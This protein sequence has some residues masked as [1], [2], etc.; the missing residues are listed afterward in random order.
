MPAFGQQA[1]QYSF[2]H[3]SVSDGLAANMVSVVVQDK[4]GYMWIATLNGL[5]RYDGSSFITFKSDEKNPHTIPSNHILRLH[6]DRKNNLWVI[7]ENNEVGIFD[8]KKFVYKKIAIPIEKRKFF[9]PQNF[10]EMPTGELLLV[11]TD[12]SLLQYTEAESKFTPVP[13]LIPVPPKWK[14]NRVAW[15]PSIKKFWITT[16]SGL[17]QYNP[18][19]KTLNYRGHNTENDPVIKSFDKKVY[20]FNVFTD[21]KGNVL[22]YYWEKIDGEPYVFRYHRK[23]NKGEIFTIH[24]QSTHHDI[25]GFLQQQDGKLWVYGKPFFAEMTDSENPFLF[26]PNEYRNEQ[27]IKFDYAFQSFEDRERNIWIATDN[28]LF[29]FNP[30]AQIFNTYNLIRPGDRQ[31][32]LSSVKSIAEMS[33]GKI[34]VGSMGAGLFYFDNNFNPLP[35]P[36]SLEPAGRSLLIWDMAINKKTGDLW[37]AMESGNLGIYNHQKN[38]YTQVTPEI[39]GNTIISHID[40]D[41]SGNIW[42]GTN[43][44]KVV[45]WDIKKAGNDPHKGYEL[46]CETS[47]IRK[48]HYDYQGYVW[49]GTLG[50]GVLK[51]DVR[52]NKII[53]T[54][55]PDNK[56]GE[57]LF[58]Y[59]PEDMTYYNDSTLLI[60]TGCINIVNTKTNKISFLTTQHGLPSN[61]IQSIQ[62]DKTGIVWVGMTNGICRVNLQKKIISYYDR[63]DGIAD[64]K[65]NTAGVE[66]LKDGR[67]LFLTDHNFLL[68]NPK[69]FGQQDIPPKPFVTSFKLA[70]KPLLMDSLEKA[71]KITLRHNKTSIAIDFTAFRYLQQRKLHYFYMLEGLDKEWVHTDYPV[72]AVYNFLPPGDYTFK[73]KS[74][75]ADGM[76]SQEIA[77][78]PIIVRP[79]FWNTWWFYGLIILLIITVLYMLDHERMS[80]RRL[81]QHMRSQIGMN[82][83]KEVSTTLNNINVLSE[84]AKIKADKNIEQSKDY[85]DQISYKSRYMIEA[86]DDML[87]SI[88]PQNDSMKKTVLRIKELT[89]GFKSAYNVDIDLIVASKVEMLELNMKL[90]HELYFFYKEAIN[91]FI[92]HIC[93]NQIFVSINQVRSRL[94]IE[95]LSE[96]D[97]EASA[98]TQSFKKA[99]HKRLEVLSSAAVETVTDG[100]RF[101]VLVQMH[102]HQ[103]QFI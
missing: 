17:V 29:L 99:M 54:F 7:G 90:R 55:S 84:I 49:V 42:F 53:R 41:T 33:D 62:K 13:N 97:E 96:C 98:F 47:M 92:T 48:V 43:K 80:K 8:T 37:I 85:I 83:H 100:N 31:P 25:R 66:Q 38:R 32:T 75:N 24:T 65:F 93:C 50:L 102:L 34:L 63:R 103:D 26:L 35:L 39:F 64:D 88:D 12:G 58:M 94:V 45:K 56:P 21:S 14:R 2:K 10:F 76:T 27:S 86:M 67:I 57:R 79:P 77:S 52:T 19:T 46:I 71:G 3:F 68:F 69:T 82:L 101:S 5:Q 60:A 20:A 70:G 28:G 15:D 78:L 40:E 16:D 59:S 61:T 1:K 73:V 72:E 18:A 4:E 87:W 30:A 44:G 6:I 11:K 89:E 23:R 36:S 95:I 22:I 81:I 74:E 91:F 9:L 51:I